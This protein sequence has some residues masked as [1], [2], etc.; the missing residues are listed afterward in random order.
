[1]EMRS[2][3]SG[4]KQRR[5]TSET[6]PSRQTYRKAQCRASSCL[7]KTAVSVVWLGTLQTGGHDARTANHRISVRIRRFLRSRSPKAHGTS[8]RIR[9]ISLWVEG[10]FRGG[11]GTLGAKA[12]SGNRLNIMTTRR[13][14]DTSLALR[15]L[16]ARKGCFLFCQLLHDLCGLR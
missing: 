4:Q 5:P 12:R 14:A 16:T 3:M 13:R 15:R 6:Q 7:E 11:H 2:C 1:M 8:I 9:G 10:R